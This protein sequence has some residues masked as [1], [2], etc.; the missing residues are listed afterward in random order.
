MEK[1]RGIVLHSIKYGET[2][3]VAHLYTDMQGRQ[4][5]MLNGVRGAAQR[6][7]SSLIQPLFLLDIEAY[8]AR[9]Q[10]AM[11]RMKE[12]RASVPLQSLPFDVHKNVIALFIGEVLY[13]L[14]REEEQNEALF[15][16]L[17]KYILLLDEM[18]RGVS[19]FHLYFLAQLA[20]HLGFFPGNTHS[21]EY[22]YFDMKNGVFVPFA[23]QHGVCMD[24][25]TSALLGCLIGAAFDD[26]QHIR[27]TREQ[28][29]LLLRKLL[30]YYCTHL[31]MA[32]PIRSLA[33]LEE[34]FRG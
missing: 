4:T 33:V 14:I 18:Q 17:S 29:S 12:F 6:Q 13:K 20:R 28:R 26:L 2:S 1:L 27:T 23:P 8:P 7:R 19:N 5:Y 31:G 11:R 3:L 15:G 10:G 30:D 24:K 22:A 34:V 25:P 16:F 21:A 32:N 9:R